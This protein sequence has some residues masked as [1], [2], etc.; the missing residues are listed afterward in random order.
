MRNFT[1]LI[2]MFSK[3]LEK[4]AHA[5]SLHYM[6]YN[7]GRPHQPLTK[8]FGKPMPATATGSPT[9]GGPLRAGRLG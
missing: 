1:R 7:F 2:N 3:K 4:L 9:V 8:Q 5:A 6:H